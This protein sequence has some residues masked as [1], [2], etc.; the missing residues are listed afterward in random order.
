MIVLPSFFFSSL[1]LK[2]GADV[3]RKNRDNLIPLDLVKDSECDL[4]DLLRGEAGLL[5]AAKKGDIDR[6][7]ATAARERERESQII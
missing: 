2:N 7:R 6:V 3:D 4:A 1:F 5:D